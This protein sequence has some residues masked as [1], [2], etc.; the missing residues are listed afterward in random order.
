[1]IHPRRE[2]VKDRSGLGRG[3][4]CADGREQAVPRG[5][6]PL[7]RRGTTTRITA[8]IAAAH[9]VQKPRA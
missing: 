2:G 1:M 6:N 5:S 4:S 3:A 9:A 8:A 7:P